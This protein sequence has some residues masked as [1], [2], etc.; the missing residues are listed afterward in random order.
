MYLKIIHKFINIMPI[1][2]CECCKYLTERLSNYNR[3]LNSKCHLDKQIINQTINNTTNNITNITNNTVNIT[4]NI[5]IV[6]FRDEDT[7]F[8]TDKQMLYCICKAPYSVAELTKLINCNPDK[9]E[10][11]NV[12]ISSLKDKSIKVIE[13]GKWVTKIKRKEL[14]KM[15]EERDDKLYEWSQ[16]HKDIYVNPCNTFNKYYMLKDKSDSLAMTEYAI[17]DNEN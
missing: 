17:Y 1:Y 2:R 13:N 6:D 3:H 12:I 11:K 4:N 10:Y 14:E 7:S 15:F 8:L 9:P 16:E 5:K